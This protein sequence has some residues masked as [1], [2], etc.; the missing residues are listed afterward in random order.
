MTKTHLVRHTQSDWRSGPDREREAAPDLPY[1]RI[2][3]PEYC[4]F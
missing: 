3:P 4:S 2:S 1:Q